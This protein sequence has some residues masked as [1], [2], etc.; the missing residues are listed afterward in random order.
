MKILSIFS[1][2]I[3]LSFLLSGCGNTEKNDG[4]SYDCTTDTDCYEKYGCPE[5]RDTY[6]PLCQ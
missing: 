3:L 6:N 4:N 1:L 2:L 5:G